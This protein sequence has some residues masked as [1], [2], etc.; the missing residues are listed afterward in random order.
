M[1]SIRLTNYV[2]SAIR[3]ALL[4]ATFD[5]ECAS[6]QKRQQALA[7][8]VVETYYGKKLIDALRKSPE[9]LVNANNYFRVKLGDGS[10]DQMTFKGRDIAPNYGTCLVLTGDIDVKVRAFFADNAA[11][12][13]RRNAALA[14]FN[15]I[16]GSMSTVE[17][18]VAVWPEIAPYCPKSE[19]KAMALIV[20]PEIVNGMFGLPA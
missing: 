2:R 3:I 6:L 8:E 13:E 16:A 4:A 9:A 15:A 7:K 1:A 14:Q 18:L 5:K 12:T 19:A 10:V 20:R 11:F 17:K